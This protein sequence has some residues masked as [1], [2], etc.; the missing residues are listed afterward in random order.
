MLFRVRFLTFN[1]SGSIERAKGCFV[2]ASFL[3]YRHKDNYRRVFFSPLLFPHSSFHALSTF[4]PFSVAITFAVVLAHFRWQWYKVNGKMPWQREKIERRESES[5]WVKKARFLSE[6]FS[7]IGKCIY[8]L[9]CDIFWHNCDD[10]LY[11]TLDK[12]FPIKIKFYYSLFFPVRSRSLT[13]RLRFV[14]YF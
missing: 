3:S 8:I 1:L 6:L 9:I 7:L 11:Y 13:L 14:F 2:P 4:F 12:T 5:E 10:V